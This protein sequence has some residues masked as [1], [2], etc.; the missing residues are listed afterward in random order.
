MHFGATK[1]YYLIIIQGGTSL[2]DE[3]NTI[4]NPSLFQGPIII[5]LLYFTCTNTL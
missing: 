2:S 3:T 4:F 5:N 1:S